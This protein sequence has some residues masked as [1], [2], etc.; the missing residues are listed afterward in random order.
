[1]SL[2][3]IAIRKGENRE[4]EVLEAE[5]LKRLKRYVK[6]DIVDVKRG[7]LKNKDNSELD[8]ERVLSLLK[9]G[10]FVIVL[11]ETGK[12]YTSEEF[13]WF[14]EKKLVE[15]RSGIVFVI[16]GPEGIP[17][18]IVQRANG[19]LSLS[20]MTFPHKLA[21][22]LLIEA[23]YRAYDLMHGGNYHKG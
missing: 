4:I 9:P 5:Y 2:K 20:K 22:L 15:C 7:K 14:I 1:M 17:V 21:R 18:K 3:I 11:A 12:E 13:S 8:A 6:V 23:L 10:E 19:V 16:G